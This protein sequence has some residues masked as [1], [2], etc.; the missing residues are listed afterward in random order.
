MIKQVAT[1]TAILLAVFFRTYFFLAPY[2]VSHIL[3][4]QNYNEDRWRNEQ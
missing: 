2:A 3:G 4:D 1:V